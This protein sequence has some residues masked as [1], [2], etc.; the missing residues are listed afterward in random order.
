[1][2]CPRCWYSDRASLIFSSLSKFRLLFFTICPTSRHNPPVLSLWSSSQTPFCVTVKQWLLSFSLWFPP[3]PSA[4]KLGRYVPGSEFRVELFEVCGRALAFVLRCSDSV[5][6]YVSVLCRVIT[7]CGQGWTVFRLPE[8]Y[9]DVLS[10]ISLE[11]YLCHRY[12]K[13]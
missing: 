13:Y 3:F 2:L 5:F 8:W 10:T 12:I 7:E 1:M 11:D 6:M 4:C 9:L